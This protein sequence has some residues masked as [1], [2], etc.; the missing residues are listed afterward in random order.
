MNLSKFQG[1][2]VWWATWW[3]FSGGAII[4]PVC[5]HTERHKGS[6]PGSRRPPGRGHSNPLQYSCLEDPWTEEPGGLPSIGSQ[7]VGLDWSDL[8][9]THAR[10]ML[11]PFKRKEKRIRI[12]FP[13]QQNWM[14]ENARIITTIYS[15]KEKQRLFFIQ[16]NRSLHIKVTDEQL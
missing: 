13:K 10:R 7:S 11:K 5:Q 3:R 2:I 14:P 4:E 12:D 15:S 1:R 16:P 6:I 8:A 9:C